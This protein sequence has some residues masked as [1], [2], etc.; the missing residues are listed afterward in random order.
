M[1]ESELFVYLTRVL[2]ALGVLSVS[3]LV[4]VRYSKKRSGPERD[5]AITK[6]NCSYKS[7][8]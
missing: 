8:D 6:I 1:A 7:T 3:A 5:G 4:L 2:I